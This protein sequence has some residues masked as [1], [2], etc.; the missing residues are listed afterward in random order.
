MKCLLDGQ[1]V[2]LYLMT[3]CLC[4]IHFMHVLPDAKMLLCICYSSYGRLL[5]HTHI[6]PQMLEKPQ[7]IKTSKHKTL[8]RKTTR[9]TT[10][11]TSTRH[12][13]EQEL[14]TQRSLKIKKW[15]HYSNVLLMHKGAHLHKLIMLLLLIPLPETL[16]IFCRWL[17]GLHNIT[18]A[19]S[20]PCGKFQSKM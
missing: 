9:I 15:F 6:C 19:L 13:V 18:E 10:T 11:I 5:Y 3:M 8:K 14:V 2:V 7:N 1:N 16:T 12:M 4:L 20:I 17:S